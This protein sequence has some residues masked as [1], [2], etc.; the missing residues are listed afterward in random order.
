[1]D[2]YFKN[3]SGC[4][5]CNHKPR[6]LIEIPH[7]LEIGS[8]SETAHHSPQADAGHPGFLLGEPDRPR[9]HGAEVEIPLVYRKDDDTAI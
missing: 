2:R 6:H 4:L 3:R 7:F 8:R 5:G 1:M 9:L